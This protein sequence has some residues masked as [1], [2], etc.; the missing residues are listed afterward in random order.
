MAIISIFIRHIVIN[1]VKIDEL[2]NL[3]KRMISA[4]P[5]LKVNVCVK[6]FALEWL[7]SSMIPIMVNAS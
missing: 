4:N 6:K 3:A 2:I 5:L 7:L 1:E